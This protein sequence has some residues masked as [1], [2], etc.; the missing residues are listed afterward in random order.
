M[1]QHNSSIDFATEKIPII[2]IA[3]SKIFK[4]NSQSLLPVV[5]SR[6]EITKTIKIEKQIFKKT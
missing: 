2:C 5:K 6:L 3:E 1:Q 4:I